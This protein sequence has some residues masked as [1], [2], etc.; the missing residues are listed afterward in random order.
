[1]LRPVIVTSVTSRFT[2]TDVSIIFN[3]TSTKNA[4]FCGHALS[5]SFLSRHFWNEIK[6]YIG[7]D[8]IISVGN[9]SRSSLHPCYILNSKCGHE[10]CVAFIV[11]D[12]HLPSMKI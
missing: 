8:L 10:K 12:S 2:Q 9:L 11:H 7:W 1:M 3:V 5:K 6:G 4:K